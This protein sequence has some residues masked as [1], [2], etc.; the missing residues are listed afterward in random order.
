MSLSPF[1]LILALLIIFKQQSFAFESKA[2]VLE[3]I[4]HIVRPEC[5]LI[6]CHL[7]KVKCE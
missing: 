7:N 3:A 2:V 5:A 6:I 1:S 4:N